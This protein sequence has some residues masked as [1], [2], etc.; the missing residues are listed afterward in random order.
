MKFLDKINDVIFI[1][2][3][4]LVLVNFFSW[5]RKTQILS[6]FANLLN[7]E[8]RSNQLIFTETDQ[9]KDGRH[10]YTFY[11]CLYGQCISRYIVILQ[12]DNLINQRKTAK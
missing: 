6:K 2:Q 9:K 4:I 7:L 1:S 8:F 12:I 3:K 11:N 5:K 10:V